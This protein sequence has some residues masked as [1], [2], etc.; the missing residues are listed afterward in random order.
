ME[1][2][3]LY[4]DRVL[5]SA[6]CYLDDQDPFNIGWAYKLTFNDGHEASNELDATTTDVDGALSE[7]EAI[8][9]AHGS[10]WDEGTV[11]NDNG[12]VTWQATS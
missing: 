1:P 8:V 5:T 4:H 6:T 10:L 11:S 3:T 12:A 2:N 7:L 9:T